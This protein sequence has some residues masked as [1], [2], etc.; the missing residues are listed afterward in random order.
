MIMSNGVTTRKAAVKMMKMIKEN[1]YSHS[2]IRLGRLV[3]N[4]SGNSD[5]IRPLLFG[6]LREVEAML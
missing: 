6:C 2:K 3:A 4:D 1:E 5:R